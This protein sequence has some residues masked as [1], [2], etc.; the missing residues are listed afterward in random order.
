MVAA[1][2]PEDAAGACRGLG[3]PVVFVLY[4][5]GLQWWK[6]T[7]E[8]P[9]HL[10]TI[11]VRS[12]SRFFREHRQDLAPH[13]VYRAKTW[14]HFDSQYQL[15]FV[16]L[17]LMP[18]VEGQIGQYVS[19]LVEKVVRKLKSQLWPRQVTDAHGQW[20]LK[21]AFWLVAAKILADKRVP[22]FSCLDLSHVDDVFAHLGDHYGTKKR[23]RIEGAAQRAALREVARDVSRFNSMQQVTTESLA[24]V[25]EN[26]LVSKETRSKLGTHSTPP[27]LVDY[28]VWQL[29][30]W[31][32]EIPEPQRHVFEPACGHAAF[33]VGAMR[34]LKDLLPDGK[35]GKERYLRQ[36]LHGLDIDPFALEIARLS[37]TL[38][39]IP[40]PDGWDLQ[41]ADVFGSAS[42]EDLAFGPTIALANPPF[43]NFNAGEKQKY[44][45]AIHYVNK[46]AELLSRVAPRIRPGGVLGFVLPQGLLHGKNASDLRGV[47]ARDY[48][49][50]EICLFPD[51]VFAFSDMESAVLIARR[52]KAR[53]AATP[54]LRYRRVR[55]PDIDRF[56]QS[57]AVTAEDRVRQDRFSEQNAWNMQIA[58]LGEVWEW[59]RDL[60]CLAAVAHVGKGLDYRGRDLPDGA[61]RYSERRLPGAVRGFTKVGA[62]LSIHGLPSEV[63]MNLNP[64]VIRCPGTGTTVGSPQ[65]LLNYAPVSRGPWRLK[66]VIDR[67][68]HAVTSTFTTVR[69]RCSSVRLEYLWALLNSPFANA[70]VYAH[71]LKRHVLVGVVREMP[72]PRASDADIQAVTEAA[73]A[74]IRMFATTES[75]LRAEADSAAGRDLLMRMDAEVLRLY[76]L[77]PRVERGLLDLFA[78]ERRP[79]VPFVFDRYYPEDYE[80]CFPLHEYLSDA[81]QRST[82]GA[83]R[84]RHKGRMPAALRA[85]F[86]AAL[87]AFAE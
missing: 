37:L 42:A 82:A 31:V 20:L 86:D 43:E 15:T 63:W 14:G 71:C 50:G 9:E 3:A 62:R 54:M 56:R 11:P 53:R 19:N 69:P 12:L 52:R 35:R 46:A 55:E 10:E 81:Y 30:P 6:Q 18:L 47:I 26:A 70:Y 34:L 78:D 87:D 27:Y 16:D 21:S 38:A 5:G 84:E 7:P 72:I 64:E 66:A 13:A 79:G 76:D 25:Y 58:E 68:G 4:R 24:Y 22:A 33:L 32:K 1:G 41:T 8:R 2:S 60:S 85:A 28:I 57:Y 40:H 67:E 61:V 48:E 65:A 59:C 36:H 80:P 51:K 17:G 77:P 74:Y 23:L 45:G 73:L 44:G 83:L 39:D 75:T 49:I 29:A